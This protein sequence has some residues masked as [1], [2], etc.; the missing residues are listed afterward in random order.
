MQPRLNSLRR[1]RKPNLELKRLTLRIRLKR[2]LTGC[3]KLD[4]VHDK[5]HINRF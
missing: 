4:K 1:R 5:I 2:L 3:L